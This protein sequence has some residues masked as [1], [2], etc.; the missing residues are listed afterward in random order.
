MM[1]NKP[2]MKEQISDLIEYCDYF[3][4]LLDSHS[5]SDDTPEGNM[6]AQV[7]WIKER[8]Q[9]NDISLP[10][11]KE[12]LSTIRYIYADGTLNHHASSPENVY[13]EIEVPMQRIIS[14]AK[15]AKLLFKMEYEEYASR[16]IEALISLLE[17]AERKLTTDENNLIYELEEI[18]D[19]LRNGTVIPPLGNPKDIYPSYLAVDR[20][21]PTISDLPGAKFL[22]KSISAIVFNGVRPDSWIDIKSADEETKELVQ[23]RNI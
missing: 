18:K 2:Y 13:R 4:F 17:S 7:I 22:I 12:M 8:A 20:Y 11:D 14:I 23:Y 21:N 1:K 19:G 15:N 16:Y 6:K 5:K 10:I 3:I 9:N